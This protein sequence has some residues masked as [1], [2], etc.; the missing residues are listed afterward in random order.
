[1]VW[2]HASER[3]LEGRASKEERRYSSLLFSLNRNIPGYDLTLKA[4]RDNVDLPPVV[5]RYHKEEV[6]H[7][8]TE[9]VYVKHC[10]S[11]RCAFV[12]TVSVGG[13]EKDLMY[14]YEPM[15]LDRQADQ[16]GSLLARFQCRDLAACFLEVL[17]SKLGM[18]LME[19]CA[20][21]WNLMQY[22]HVMRVE[23]G[24][25]VPPT[26]LRI[27]SS[28]KR[29]LVVVMASVGTCTFMFVC[30]LVMCYTVGA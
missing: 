8:G 7:V 26:G 2:S 17:H 3:S 11:T 28:W 13:V 19:I 24:R 21:T 14:I 1:M 22:K 30:D 9:S 5:M 27:T 29:M 25:G 10:R 4:G 18:K 23:A 16:M 6:A 15:G 20:N 12:K